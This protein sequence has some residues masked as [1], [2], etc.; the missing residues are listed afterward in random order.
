MKW[1]E[2]SIFRMEHEKVGIIKI[3]KR[4]TGSYKKIEPG[5]A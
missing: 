4:A 2:G 1:T 3:D 5:Q